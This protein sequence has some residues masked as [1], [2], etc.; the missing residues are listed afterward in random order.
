MKQIRHIGNISLLLVTILLAGPWVAGAVRRVPVPSDGISPDVAVSD[1]GTVFMVFGK[2]QSAFLSVSRDGGKTF[3]PPKQLNAPGERVLVGHERGPKIALGQDGSIHVVWTDEKSTR[4][5]Y[6]RGDSKGTGFSLPRNLRDPGANVDEATIA[7]DESGNVL[8]TWLDSRN[9]PDPENPL[10]LPVFYV[11]SR[12]DGKAFSHNQ[13][14]R[15]EPPIRACSC[16][17]HE[18]KVLS[19]GEF[20]LAFRGAYHNVRDLFMA[21][22][23]LEKGGPKVSVRKIKNQEWHFEACPMSGP[24]LDRTESPGW[25]LAAWMSDGRVYYAESTNGTQ[26][27]SDAISDVTPDSPPA[28]HPIVLAN[29]RGEVFFAWEIGRHIRWQ[30]RDAAGKVLESGDA[31]ELPEKSKSTGFVDRQGDFCLVF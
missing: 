14:L 9:P 13:L 21:R 16:C 29:A 4:V 25:I 23:S 24:F 6:T 19:P 28:N 27:F 22:I 18:T 3:A 11:E 2:N 1:S 17:A 30:T 8:I 26:E 12:D 5:E 10:S 31:G 20:A 7:A 15:A